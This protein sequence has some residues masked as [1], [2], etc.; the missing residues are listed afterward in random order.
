M[1][2][3]R[4]D[5]VRV[6]DPQEILATLDFS[7]SLEGV[8]FMPEMV[9]YA[10]GQY[11]VSHR[12]EKIC[13]TIAGG[14]ARRMRDTVFL[15]DM[16]CDGGGHGG[17][18]ARCRIYWKTAWLEKIDDDQAR[19][20]TASP[21][22]AQRL[23][24]ICNQAARSD[25]EGSTVFRC[26]AT[27]AVRAT[28]PQTARAP[29]QYAREIACG[30]ITLWQFVT[31]ACRAIYLKT[32]SKLGNKDLLPLKLPVKNGERGL[33]ILLKPGDWVEVKSFDDIA[34][35]LN[36]EARNRGLCFTHEMLP[37]CGKKFRVLDRVHRIIDEKTGRMIELKNDCFILDGLYCEGDRSLGRWFCPRLIYPY[38]RSAWL[39]PVPPPQPAPGQ[40]KAAALVSPHERSD[41]R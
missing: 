24:T 20:R 13:D 35:T 34:K 6:R 30:N 16:R 23:E 37:A 22:E 28:E 8:P 39:R 7:G 36:G 14:V 17:C 26:Q 31:T 25:D 18:G 2:L 1:S 27:E 4:G 33:P 19:Y 21:D 3:K 10:G 29:G 12:V 9:K 5:R 40:R 38:W 32:R 41:C 15:E 11:T